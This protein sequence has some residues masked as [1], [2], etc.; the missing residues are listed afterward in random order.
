MIFSRLPLGASNIPYKSPGFFSSFLSEVPPVTSEKWN[1]RFPGIPWLDIGLVGTNVDIEAV[2]LFFPKLYKFLYKELPV[3]PVSACL[4]LLKSNSFIP[5]HRDFAGGTPF[6]VLR[7]HIP[8]ITDPN[9]HLFVNRFKY[10][11]HFALFGTLILPIFILF[12]TILP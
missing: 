5:E 8:L 10:H 4:S 9:I 7:I 6:G 11:L 12:K 3:L 1:Q 2:S